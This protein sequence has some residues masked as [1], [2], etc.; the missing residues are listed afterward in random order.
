MGREPKT[1]GSEMATLITS[2]RYLDQETVESKMGAEDYDVT[3]SPVFVIDGADYQII[4][5]GHHSLAAAIADGVAPALK[6]ANSSNFDAIG[7]LDAG[8]V[9]GFL[10]ASWMGDDWFEFATG[11]LVF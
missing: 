3:V 11:Q 2:Q 9:E 1:Q 4:I 10:A 6:V 8:D 5:D 7:I